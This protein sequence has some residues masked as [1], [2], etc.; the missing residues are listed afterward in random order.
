MLWNPLFPRVLAAANWNSPAQVVIAGHK[1]AVERAVVLAKQARARAV[2]LPVSA[3]FHC[4][5]MTPAQERLRI[6][7]EATDF[8]DL[9]V[10]LV[11][12]WQAAEIR[13]G[14][15]ARRG[16]IEQVPNAV[17]WEQ[18]IRHL[19]SRGVE[20]FVEVGPGAV[21]TG[22]LRNIDSSLTGYPFREPG[23]WDSIAVL[24]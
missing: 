7:L 1:G 2:P 11:N 19:A 18:S 5:L 22:L 21:L 9:D 12:N 15:E 6:D 16:L 10:P 13:T 20:Q 24:L 23:D 3:P 8:A 14:T 4:S 17:Q